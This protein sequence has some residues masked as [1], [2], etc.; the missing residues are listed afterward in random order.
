ML[1][2]DPDDLDTPSCYVVIDFERPQISLEQNDVIIPAYPLAGDMVLVQGDSDN[3]W[4]AHIIS[5][6]YR[7]SHCQVTF[8]VQDDSCPGRYKKEAVRC[9]RSVTE[10]IHWDSIV[11]KASGIWEG[12]FRKE[13]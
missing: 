4:H 1:Y 3:L 11:R 12:T 2:P 13:E 7:S 8:Y 9:S 5:V 6:N 10:T